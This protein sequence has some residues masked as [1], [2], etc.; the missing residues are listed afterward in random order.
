MKKMIAKLTV[1]FFM[2]ACGDDG[3]SARDQYNTTE[4]STNSERM[5]CDKT[6][7]CHQNPKIACANQPYNNECFASCD[8]TW[9]ISEFHDYCAQ[10]CEKKVGIPSD[11]SFC[12]QENDYK[13]SSSSSYEKSSSSR[14]DDYGHLTSCNDNDCIVDSRD[15]QIY[16]T[17]TIGGQTW[18]AENLNYDYQVGGQSYGSYCYA[19]NPVNCKK[20]GRLYT[21]GAMVDSAN[22]GGYG[23]VIKGICPKFWH[24]P[25][26]SEFKTLINFVGENVAGTKLKSEEGWDNDGGGEDVYAFSVLPA[27]MRGLVT[28][29]SMT[30]EVCD[31]IKEECG[32]WG[33][34]FISCDS[35][36]AIV[37][38]YKGG[39]ACFATSTQIQGY[40]VTSMVVCFSSKLINASLTDKG[41]Y[42]R[43]KIAYSIRCLKD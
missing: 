28:P 32:G 43:K 42:Y 20:Y 36:V 17:V 14:F 8:I 11:F 15:G 6:G 40:S 34:T 1:A 19:N 38:E 13:E 29:A 18:M 22:H 2:V 39:Q 25:T 7:I 5:Y 31:K 3:S 41:Y 9:N 23:S 33:A 16:R 24:I 12:G 35:S 21:Y 27:G 30:D 26:E 37:D 4:S 10:I